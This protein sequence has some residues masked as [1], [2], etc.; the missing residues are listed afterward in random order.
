MEIKAHLHSW[1]ATPP[2]GLSHSGTDAALGHILA[3]CFALSSPLALHAL[4]VK[5]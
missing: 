2:P 1:D 4:S 3:R 5:K